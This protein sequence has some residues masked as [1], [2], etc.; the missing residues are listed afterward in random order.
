MFGIAQRGNTTVETL[1]S[2]NC[3][4]DAGLISVGQVL[5]V[6]SP[7]QAR[8]PSTVVAPATID[9]NR[10]TVELWWIIKG[11]GGNNGFPAGCDDSIALQQSGIPTNLSMDETIKRAFAYLTDD[12]NVGTGQTGSGWWNPMSTTSLKMDSY[13]IDGNHVTAYLSGDF[14]TGGVCSFT[15]YEPQIVLNVMTLTHTKSATIYINGE[16]YRQS[17]DMSGQDQ[18]TSYTWEEFQRGFVEFWLISKTGNHP[19]AKQVGCESYIVP[20]MTTTYATGDLTQDLNTALFALFLPDRQN[21]EGITNDLLDDQGLFVESVTIENSHATVQIGGE[22]Q[23]I[24]TCADPVFEAQIIQTI[25][26]FDDIQSATVT[27][28]GMNLREFVDMSGRPE[29]QDHVYRR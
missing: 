24:G 11:D 29:V 26:Q 23:G 9:P 15:Q 10:Y 13:T 7:I 21:P 5:Y 25:F 6:P 19:R 12:A 8:P 20:R 16:N 2:G 22:L 1:V 27:N 14:S 4:V 3:L 17:N 18:R 28:K